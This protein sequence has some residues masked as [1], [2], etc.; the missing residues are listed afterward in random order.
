MRPRTHSGSSEASGD[1]DFKEEQGERE[2]H[3]ERETE[4]ERQR[5]RERQTDRQRQRQ[6]DRQRQTETETDRQAGRQAGRQA[7]RQ[8]QTDRQT[9]RQ[10]QRQTDRQTDRDTETQ[11][12]RDTERERQRGEE[13]EKEINSHQGPTAVQQPANIFPK[14]IQLQDDS[15]SDHMLIAV[16]APVIL[17]I[18]ECVKR[19]V[20]LWP[21][22]RL[23]GLGSQCS[24]GVQRV[25]KMLLGAVVA[26]NGPSMLNKPRCAC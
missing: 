15:Q 9:D 7:D 19:I 5:E 14:D 12:E 8:R 23:E 6:T 18:P 10:R 20:H 11:R 21:D 3:T 13:E 4:R 24:R 22:L 17:T 2:T 16:V 25:I 1:C 26:F